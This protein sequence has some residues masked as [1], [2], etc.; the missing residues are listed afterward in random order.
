VLLWYTR[1][2]EADP[3]RVAALLV[4]ILAAHAEL[5]LA[6]LGEGLVDGA[7]AAF[8]RAADSAGFGFRIDWLGYRPG[9]L[10]E[11]VAGQNGNLIA[12]YP[13]DDDL[14]NRA[15]CPSKLP[16]LMGLGVPVVAEA[17]GEVAAYLDAVGTRSL[18]PAG[19]APAFRS[20]VRDLVLDRRLRA[21]LAHDVVNAAARWSW[22][23]AAG[24]LMA[25][26]R[27]SLSTLGVA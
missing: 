22:T 15:R 19:D 12:I 26:Y 9:L 27:D 13:M 8:Q 21:V 3:R 14:A 10:E 20:R 25:W 18:A 23:T 5:R 2:T 4:P 16:H 17:V 24:G 7:E 6:V 1:F 11:Y